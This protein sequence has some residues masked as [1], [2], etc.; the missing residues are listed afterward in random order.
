MLLVGT[1]IHEVHQTIF[2]ML[3][4]AI[5]APC[6]S[7]FHLGISI[8][9]STMRSSI[10]PGFESS[11]CRFRNLGK[12]DHSTL[13]RVHSTLSRVH[14]TLSRVHST[15]SRVHSTLSRVHSTL[16]RVHSTLSRVHSTLSRVHS[17]LSR[18]HST[19][20]RVH[21]TL[22]RVHSTLSRVHSAEDICVHGDMVDE[23]PWWT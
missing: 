9:S 6:P 3:P 1:T 19:L 17:T 10:E 23:L 15:L 21:S 20:S 11:Y 22:S 16:S 2:K 8:P 7:T 14:S 18:V 12:F 5:I 13:S 4:S